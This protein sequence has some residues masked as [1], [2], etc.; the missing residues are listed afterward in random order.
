MTS[1]RCYKCGRFIAREYD[2][3]TEFFMPVNP[4]KTRAESLDEPGV[5]L[6]VF[7]NESCADLLK[8]GDA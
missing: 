2:R 7:C 8:G 5:E 6:S 4:D 3:G 1:E